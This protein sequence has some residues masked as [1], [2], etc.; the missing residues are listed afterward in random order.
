MLRNLKQTYNIF[1]YVATRKVFDIL[2]TCVYNLSQFHSI[3]EFLVNIQW[4]SFSKFRRI[5][6]NVVANDFGDYRTPVTI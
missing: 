5:F 4:N 3:D 6:T 2:M 1:W